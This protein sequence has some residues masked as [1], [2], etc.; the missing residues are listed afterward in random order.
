MMVIDGGHVVGVAR[1]RRGQRAF[2]FR[3]MERFGKRCA[4]TGPQPALTLEAAHLYSFAERP[5]H[6]PDGGLLLRRDCHRLFDANLL[7]VNPESWRVEVAP[8]LARYPTYQQLE[9][10]QIDRQ[11]R[12]NR[13][14]VAAHYLT[15]MDVFVASESAE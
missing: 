7:A 14:L 9:G 3:M 12:P 5:E 6:Q 8:T 10:V 11:F 4:F 13:D 2:R 15:S 1:R